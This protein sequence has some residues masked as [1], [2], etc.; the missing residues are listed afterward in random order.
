MALVG[1]TVVYHAYPVV[2]FF[3]RL[4]LNAMGIALIFACGI[5]FYT[6]IKK[7]GLME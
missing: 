4:G 5:M 6:E 3:A 1:G 7:I 2:N